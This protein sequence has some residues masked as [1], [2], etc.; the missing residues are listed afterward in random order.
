MLSIP[1]LGSSSCIGCAFSPPARLRPHW[2]RQLTRQHFDIQRF[3]PTSSQL[4]KGWTSYPDVQPYPVP[5]SGDQTVP[6]F[7]RSVLVIAH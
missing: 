7:N 2:V 3:D 6:C 5:S 4:A 1:A